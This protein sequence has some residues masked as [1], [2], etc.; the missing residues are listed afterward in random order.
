M[1]MTNKKTIISLAISSVFL[2]ACGGGNGGS[3]PSIDS[4]NTNNQSRTIS[5]SSGSVKSAQKTSKY[6]QNSNIDKNYAKSGS[7]ATVQLV[8]TGVDVNKKTLKDKNISRN[9]VLTDTNSKFTIE[10]TKEMSSTYHGSNIAETIV[11]TAPEVTIDVVGFTQT[12]G[13]RAIAQASS[14]TYEHNKADI[15]NNSYGSAVVSAALPLVIRN[16]MI[17]EVKKMVEDGA[18]YLIAT[19]NDGAAQA[20]DTSRMPEID[21]SLLNGGYIAVTGVNPSGHAEYNKCGT[22][23]DYCVAALAHHKNTDSK[24]NDIMMGGTSTATGY[25][26]AV[27][28]QVK[29]RYDFMKGNELKDVL[30]TTADDAGEAGVDNVFGHG[31]L[32]ADKALNGYGRFDAV[33]TLNVDGQK[34]TYY[35]DNNI[36]GT[37]GLIKEGKDTLVLNG[38]NTYS[39]GTIINNGSLVVNGQNTSAVIVNKQGTLISGDRNSSVGAVVNNGKISAKHNSIM[40]VN[41]DLVATETSVIEQAIGSKIQVAGDA[42][43][44]GKLEVVGVADGYVTKEGNTEILISADSINGEFDLIDLQKVSDL[45][46]NEVLVS[47]KTVSVK[48]YRQEVGK[49]AEKQ[50]NYIGK[51]QDVQKAEHFL[52]DT[53]KIVVTATTTADVRSRLAS[54]LINSDNISKTLFEIGSGTHQRAFENQALVSIDQNKRL[55]NN[56]NGSNDKVWIDYNFSESKLDLNGLSGTQKTNEFGLGGVKVLNNHSIAFSANSVDTNWKENY[57]NIGK[58]I[59]LNGVAVDSAYQY[60]FGEYDTFAHLGYNWLSKGFKLLDTGVGVRKNIV[61]NNKFIIKP[62]MHIQYLN[63]KADNVE[64]SE[65]TS[66]KKFTN[67]RVTASFALNGTYMFTDKFIASGGVNFDRDLHN[68]TEYQSAYANLFMKQSENSSGNNRYGFNIGASYQPVKNL[69]VSA[70]FTH[71]NGKSWKNNDVNGNISYKF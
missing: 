60:K 25:V 33:K 71:K 27:A 16:G 47:D 55:I 49:V 62:E 65:N 44:D 58:N 52:Q 35:F 32:N 22:A 57:F 56:L 20:N 5:S 54:Q 15:I 9:M 4:T 19:G 67:D 50:S 70:K 28:A 31:I 14:A 43:L 45:V 6:V 30:F 29:S 48:T 24:G 13:L 7:E 12:S 23:K 64:V 11:N 40:K 3:S 38:D 61:F 39:G 2:A 59:S 66:I 36:T 69:F 51:S 17:P 42:Q 21:S 53:D 34:E 10:Q 68:K 8:D 63:T 46:K 37:G 26:S 18:L 1:N 41:G